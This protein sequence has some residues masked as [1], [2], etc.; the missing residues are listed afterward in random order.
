MPIV[1]D[2]PLCGR[3][4]KLPDELAGATVRCPLCQRQFEAL[5]TAEAVP[6]EPSASPKPSPPPEPGAS[7]RSRRCPACGQR[8]PTEALHCPFCDAEVDEEDERPWE[9]PGMSMRMDAEPH[10]GSLVL[11]LGILSLCSLPALCCGVFGAVFAV[12]GLGCGITAWVLGR[13]DLRKMTAGAMDPGGRSTTQAGV[14]CGIIG[15][16]LC[17]VILVLGLVLAAFWGALLISARNGNPPPF[18]APAPV[19]VAPRPKAPGR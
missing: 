16:C 14:T 3:K 10:R 19:P 11:T 9:R 1:M 17:S 18:M 15:T 4:V 12:A 7:A 8:I 6:A 13:K 2:C 5:L